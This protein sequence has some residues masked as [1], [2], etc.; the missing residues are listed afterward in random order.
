MKIQIRDHNRGFTILLPT[1]LFFSKTCARLA[2]HYGR[3]AA[4][5]AMAAISPE[6]LEILFAELRRIKKKHG[7]W[8]LMEVDGADGEYVKITL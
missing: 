2:N 5:E 8:D 7:V 1:G 4:P 6:A 3:K